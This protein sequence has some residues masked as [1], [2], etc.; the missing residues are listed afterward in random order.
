MVVN[1]SYTTDNQVPEKRQRAN[2]GDGIGRP[3]N[4]YKPVMTRELL[5]T[6]DVVN[7]RWLLR[8]ASKK[9]P[10]TE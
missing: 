9:I 4:K 5:E 10:N 7:D 2:I 8:K 1:N 6:P 3:T